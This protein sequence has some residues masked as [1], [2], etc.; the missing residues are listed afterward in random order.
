M[1][2][3]TNRTV[4]SAVAGLKA[5]EFSAREI[6]QAHIDAIA[7]AHAAEVT[8]NRWFI[9]SQDFIALRKAKDSQ[10]RYLLETDLTAEPPAIPLEQGA[11]DRNKRPR[12]AKLRH[13]TSI[14][15]DREVVFESG[16]NDKASRGVCRDCGARSN[17]RAVRTENTVHNAIRI[18]V[19][20]A[21]KLRSRHDR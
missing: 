20:H 14:A 3:L 12:V 10:G 17:N 16:S 19:K 4:K 9:N 7:K 15:F 11:G 21:R 8:P 18:V 6:T 2:D 13:G 5:R 1:S